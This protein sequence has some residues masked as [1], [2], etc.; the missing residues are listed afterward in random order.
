MI[1]KTPI[2]GSSAKRRDC[3]IPTA[4]TLSDFALTT[5]QIKA[6]IRADFV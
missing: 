1:A 5:R 4:L 3:I 6:L 2:S